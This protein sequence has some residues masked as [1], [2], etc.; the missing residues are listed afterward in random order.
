VKKHG[1][2]LTYT[3]MISV[4][5]VVRGDKR[6]IRMAAPEDGNTAVQLFGGAYPEKFQHAA[7]IMMEE[8]GYKII[9]I[10]FGCPVR[11]VIRIGAGSCLLREPSAMG[12]IVRAVKETGAVVSAKIRAGYSAVNI[13]KTIPILDKAGADIIILHP[14]LATQMFAGTADW[15]LVPRAREMT[16]RILIGNGDI[17][18]PENALDRLRD[19]GADGI[20]LGRAAIGK[21]YLFRQIAELDETGAYYTPTLPEVRTGLIEFARL[22]VETSSARSLSPMRSAV[23]ST[24]KSRGNTREIRGKVSSI[25]TVDELIEA[26]DGWHEREVHPNETA[27]R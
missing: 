25:S 27:S 12:E 13:E 14:R 22:F 6:T 8:Y 19:S 10:N 1:A 23:L 7:K 2:G 17:D 4:E 26:L 5:G 16:G 24:V 20:M 21:P 3:E 15:S 18:T 11:K 9:D